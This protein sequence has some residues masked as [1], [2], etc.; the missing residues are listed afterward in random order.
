MLQSFSSRG[1]MNFWKGDKLCS[2]LGVDEADR[3]RTAGRRPLSRSKMQ[4][5][6]TVTA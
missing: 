6:V 2:S 5:S 1:V 4:Y 3:G